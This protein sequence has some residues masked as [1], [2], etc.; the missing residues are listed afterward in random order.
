MSQFLLVNTS[1]RYPISI[2]VK[3]DSLDTSVIH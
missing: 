1:Q 2:L 3:Q